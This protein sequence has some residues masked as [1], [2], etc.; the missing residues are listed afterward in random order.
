VAVRGAGDEAP[1]AE[2]CMLEPSVYLYL[3]EAQDRIL[4]R[5]E[6]PPDG[7]AG[8]EVVVRLVLAGDGSVRSMRVVSYSDRRLARSAR[9]AI[10]RAAPFGPVPP[11]AACLVGLPLR[12]TLRN[13]SEREPPR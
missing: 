3:S 6:L 10:E 9:F 4:A 5:W 1:E 8:R 12:T 7:L 13:P 11:D 2:D